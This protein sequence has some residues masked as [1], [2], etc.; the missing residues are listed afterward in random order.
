[1]ELH[2]ARS[3]TTSARRS[4]RLGYAPNTRMACCVRVTGPV[5]GRAHARQ[6]RARRAL[7]RVIGFNYDRA[8]S[9]VVV[10]GNGIA[11]VTAADHLRRRHPDVEI[12]LIAEEPHHLYNRM[13][14]S[15]LVYGRSRDA[16]PLPQPR[17]LVRGARGSPRG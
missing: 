1:M 14:I 6:G 8:S 15:R 7:S 12:D 2:V 4:N 16:G 11:G 3:P 9:S 5:D 10:I 13:G 17:R